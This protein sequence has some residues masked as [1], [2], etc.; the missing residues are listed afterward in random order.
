MKEQDKITPSKNT[1]LNANMEV[2]IDKAFSLK[3]VV[4]GD[5]KK[6][7]STSTTVADFLKQQGVKLNDLDRVEP[8]LAEKVEAEN[9]VN[10]IR[11]EKVTDVVEE[12]VDFAVITKKDDSLS[13]GKEKIVKEGKDRTHF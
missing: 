10:V 9:T 13:K 11:I 7:W 4:A 8:E 6:V 12:P 3:L 5:E 1:K 2:S